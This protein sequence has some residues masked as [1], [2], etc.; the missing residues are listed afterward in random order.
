VQN[1]NFIPTDKFSKLYYAIYLNLFT[2]WGYVVDNRKNVYNPLANE[3][4]IGY[5]LG[6]D[7]VTYYDF[8]LRLEYSFNKSGQSGFFIHFMPSI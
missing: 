6:L 3:I 7:F 2:D 1:F 4:N 8:V 5:G